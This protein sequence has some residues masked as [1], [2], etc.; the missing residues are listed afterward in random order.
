M[1]YVSRFVTL[2]ENLQIASACA[3]FIS[4][5]KHH[6]NFLYMHCWKILKDQPKWMERRRH[7]NAPKPAAKKQKTIAKSSPSSA[8][9]AVTPAAGGDGDT[10]QGPQERPPK[11]KKEKHI[12]RQRAD[13]EAMEYL[14]TKKEIV[15]A[16]KEL[17]KEERF[18]KAFALQ[19]ERIRMEREKMEFKREMKE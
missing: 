17:K 2:F 13:I 18:K 5:D 7:M 4:D 15:D 1:H 19:E 8:P 9:V 10:T 6:Q 3:L 11:K 16:A 12:L 14:M